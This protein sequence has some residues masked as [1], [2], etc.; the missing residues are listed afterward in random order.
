MHGCSESSNVG[1]TNLLPDAVF[2]IRRE[3][4]SSTSIW[5]SPRLAEKTKSIPRERALEHC[6]EQGSDQLSYLP[7]TFNRVETRLLESEG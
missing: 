7:Q 5:R 2:A 1:T 6:P 3:A 4:L